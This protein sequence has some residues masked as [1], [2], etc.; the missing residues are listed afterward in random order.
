MLD[1]GI[2]SLSMSLREAVELRRLFINNAALADEATAALSDMLKCIR[3]EQL[4]LRHNSVGSDGAALLSEALNDDASLAAL[5]LGWND[6]GVTGTE[7]ICDSLRR[8]QLLDFSMSTVMIL[9][10]TVQQQSPWLCGTILR[11]HPFG[12]PPIISAILGSTV[13]QTR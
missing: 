10:A 9:V 2:V 4:H 12:S 1:R 6:I 3:V 11:S 5:L 8:N 13:C 7:F